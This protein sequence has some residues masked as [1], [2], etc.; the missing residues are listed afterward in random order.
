MSSV[1]KNLGILLLS[2]LSLIICLFVIAGYN[3]PISGFPALG[4]NEFC[5]IESHDV[6]IS[7]NDSSFS[8]FDATADIAEIVAPDDS[9]TTTVS[10]TV[11]DYSV[12]PEYSGLP[13]VSVN[14]NIPYFSD[15]EKETWIS[16]TEVYPALDYLGRCE[17]VY[18]CIGLETMP[19]E[20]EK[21][22]DIGMIK[23]S[24]WH[25][26]KY[27]GIVDGLY[28]YNR[29]HLIG[30]QLGGEN[31]NEY[32]LITGTRYLN[33]IGMLPYE[34]LVAGYVKNSGNHVIYRVT[35]YFV[36]EELIARGVLME[37]ESVEDNGLSFC[38]W[39]YNVQPGISID[40]ATGESCVVDDAVTET[41]NVYGNENTVDLILN[42]NTKKAHLPTCSSVGEMKAKNKVEFHG[43][44]EEVIEMGYSA[45]GRCHPF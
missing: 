32:N 37:A 9:A 34:N 3:N 8:D 18:A 36:G 23:P 40:Y 14:Y 42:K 15:V 5:E 19:A 39:C 7:E 31:A 11:F 25:T 26:I 10:Y 30:W 44:I 4:Q 1:L 38:V 33:V 28:L 22:G 13:S 29:C 35:P 24:G 6:E 27:P 20:G 2:D 45:C 17:T 16:G 41:P 21:R 43:T 12:V